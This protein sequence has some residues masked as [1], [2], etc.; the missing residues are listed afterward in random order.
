MAQL[1]TQPWEADRES[2]A[3]D[4][5]DKSWRSTAHKI[6]SIFSDIF[7]EI[8]LAKE[9][10]GLPNS[11]IKFSAASAQQNDKEMF[12]L[13]QAARDKLS[14]M[15]TK[16]F[17]MEIKFLEMQNKPSIIT[18]KDVTDWRSDATTARQTLD[19][20]LSIS[21][22]EVFITTDFLVNFCLHL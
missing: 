1:P 5:L 9:S 16:F 8:K 19:K 10:S 12:P 2:N 21:G 20:C 18:K 13:L 14:E 15:E 6:D 22:Y 4:R 17:K 7:D 3:P 11:N